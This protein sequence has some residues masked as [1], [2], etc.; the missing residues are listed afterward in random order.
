MCII[1]AYDFDIPEDISE[2]PDDTPEEIEAKEKEKSLLKARTHSQFAEDN[3]MRIPYVD[4]VTRMY[5]HEDPSIL[6]SRRKN[7]ERDKIDVDMRNPEEFE[8]RIHQKMTMLQAHDIRGAADNRVSFQPN[9][10]LVAQNTNPNLKARLRE[11]KAHMGVS[12]V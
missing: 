8:G 7:K 5:Q 2:I 12:E 10:E 3:G 1:V 11:Y 4:P 9:P 6:G